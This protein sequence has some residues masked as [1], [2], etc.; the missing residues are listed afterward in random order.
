MA[1]SD[2]RRDAR[3]KARITVTVMKGRGGQSLLTED[4]SFRGVFLRMDAPPALRQLVRLEMTL[5]EG[6]TI[7]AHAMVVYRVAPGGD[8]APGA[9]MQFYGLEGRERTHWESFVGKIREEA[10]RSRRSPIV[11]A[12]PDAPDPVRRRYERFA[13]RFEVRVSSLDELVSLYTRD[14]SKGGMAVETDMDLETGTEVGLD[15]VHPQSHASFELD[16]IVR[17]KIRQPTATGLALEFIGM[18]DA[19]REALARFVSAEL[20]EKREEEPSAVKDDDRLE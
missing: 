15:L 6:P 10:P 14:I 18:D 3:F 13:V 19:R 5:P 12:P 7:R 17:R 2:K 8:Q 16:A 9:G 20:G 1:P 4:V 11:L